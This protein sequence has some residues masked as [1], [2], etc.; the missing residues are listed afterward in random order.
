M[1]F[2]RKSNLQA[3]LDAPTF[4]FD[5]AVGIEPT[6]PAAEG[7]LLSVAER[8]VNSADDPRPR[9]FVTDKAYFVPLT[10]LRGIAAVLVVLFHAPMFGLA[11][12]FERATMLPLKGYIW[13]DFF[14]MLSGFVIAHSYG[15]RFVAGVSRRDL[16]DYLTARFARVYPLH[17]AMLVAFLA[18]ELARPAIFGDVYPAT[19]SAGGLGPAD[20]TMPSFFA[21]L[22]LVQALPFHAHPSWNVPAWSISCEAAVYLVF[23]VLFLALAR[24]DP[25]ILWLAA[26]LSAAALTMLYAL[27]ETP[28]SL[29]AGYNLIRCAAE[30]TIGLCLY[31]LYAG[32]RLPAI[33]ARD[34]V[35]WTVVALLILSLHLG[36]A[37][38]L[39]VVELALLLLVAVVNRG[40]LR[41]ALETRVPEF[42]GRISYSIYMVHFPV[43]FVAALAARALGGQDALLRQSPAVRVVLF[44]L[45]LAVIVALSTLTYHAI[46]AP[47]RKAIM[48]RRRR[49]HARPE[50]DATRLVSADAE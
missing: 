46:E 31:R 13:V 15:Q 40:R 44:I 6:Y 11:P 4:V 39:I 47:C 22:F 30:F 50:G 18:I 36:L 23:P 32:H 7:G 34:V 24:R 48:A 3:E 2:H 5:A 29:D 10:S 20:F 38:P 41:A 43:L 21:N 19:T 16:T 37:D 8:L 42:L 12:Y 49:R 9:S 27:S 25:S 17:L 14:F 33:L 45:A 35:A 26:L 1:L 28:H